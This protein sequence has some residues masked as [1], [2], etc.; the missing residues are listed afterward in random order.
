MA[1]KDLSSDAEILDLDTG[2]WMQNVGSLKKKNLYLPNLLCA[3]MMYFD[4][5]CGSMCALAVFTLGPPKWHLF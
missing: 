3:R 1:K 2:Y 4:P 5:K